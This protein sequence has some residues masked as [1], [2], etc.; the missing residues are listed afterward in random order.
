[1][2]LV[3]VVI[4]V[5]FFDGTVTDR[6]YEKGLAYDKTKTFIKE[7]GLALSIDSVRR[8]GVRGQAG[9]FSVELDFTVARGPGVE[10][11]VVKAIVATPVSGA[12]PASGK[13]ELK[14]LP[15]HGYRLSYESTAKGYFFLLVWVRVDEREVRLRKSF[16]LPVKGA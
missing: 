2:V 14:P 5:Q 6:H 4:G 9:N 13:I 12:P 1:M 11:E 3:T 8:V 7:S 16:Y 10:T 15:E